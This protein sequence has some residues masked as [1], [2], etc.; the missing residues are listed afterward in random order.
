MFGGLAIGVVLA[1]LMSQIRPIYDDRGTL[2]ALTGYPVLGSVSMVWT[3]AQKKMRQRR[4]LGFLF[5]LLALITAYGL[6]MSLIFLDLSPTGL[7]QQL[8]EIASL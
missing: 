3:H 5:G 2:S 1:F 7:V 6:V 8:R 4:H